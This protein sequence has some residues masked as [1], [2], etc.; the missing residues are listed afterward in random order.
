[1]SD[2]H[3]VKHL[4]PKTGTPVGATPALD[5]VLLDAGGVLILPHAGR[6]ADAVSRLGIAP[7]D[8]AAVERAHYLAVRALDIAPDDQRAPG[9]YLEAFVGALDLP[10]E[11]TADACAAVQQVWSRPSL[12]SWRTRVRGTGAGLR[13]LAATGRKLGVVSNSDGT[14]ERQLRRARICQIGTGRGTPVLVIVDSAVFGVAKPDP[15]IFQHAVAALGVTPERTLYVGDSLRFDVRGATAAGLRPVHFDPHRLCPAPGGHPHIT[16]LVQL[17]DLIS[18]SSS[19][20]ADNLD[21][22]M[23]APHD[24]GESAG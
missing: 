10:A 20:G 24:S 2:H 11:R 12:Y 21:T 17:A 4:W 6:L 22:E 14:V 5:A 16:A 15:S 1:V 3:V 18:R 8:R 13:R 19:G 9:T 23:L 7:P